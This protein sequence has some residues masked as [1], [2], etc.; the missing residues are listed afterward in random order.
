MQ[1]LYLCGA[2]KPYINNEHKRML[3]KSGFVFV[4]DHDNLEEYKNHRSLSN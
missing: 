1:W 4:V 2:T 3:L